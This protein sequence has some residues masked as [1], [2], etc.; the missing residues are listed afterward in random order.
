MLCRLACITA[1]TFSGLPAM[2]ELSLGATTPGLKLVAM[3]QLPAAPATQGDTAFCTHLFVE[4]IATPGGQDAAAKGWKVTSELAFGDLTAVSFV[5]N[6]IPATSG[7]CELIDGNVGFYAQ[8]QLVALLYSAE[9]EAL[10]IGRLRSFGDG[11]RLLSGGVLPE[12]VADIGYDGTTLGVTAP[13]GEEPVCNG[14][15]V[16]PGIENLPIDRA[17]AL[18]LQ[19]GWEP[20]PGDPAQQAYSQARDIAAAGVPEVE[21]CSGTGFAFCAYVYTGPA[22]GL[23]VVTAGE[24]GED[25]S[26]PAVSSYRVDCR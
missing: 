3:D 21:D 11:L 24:G 19:A 12:T 23:T 7:S 22:G 8:G 16:V 20:V 14:I 26:L 13:S 5:G 10:L 15:A 17:R 6:A 2:A 18:L 9:P 25:G 1:I 4:T